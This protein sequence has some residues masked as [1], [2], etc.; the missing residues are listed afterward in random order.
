M[1]Y[2]QPRTQAAAPCIQVA[3]VRAPGGEG[4]RGARDPAARGR[5][6]A[7]TLH[8]L[9]AEAAPNMAAA[10]AAAGWRA[11]EARSAAG[12]AAGAAL[13]VGRRGG[14][15][16]G[17]VCGRGG[18]RGAGTPGARRL[19]P[20]NLS[21]LHPLAAW[22]TGWAG[23]GGGIQG[24]MARVSIGSAATIALWPRPTHRPSPPHVARQREAAPPRPPHLGCP[25]SAA[26]RVPAVCI[27]AP[28]APCIAATGELSL[29]SPT[30][31]RG[32]LATPNP[33]PSPSPHPNPGE[34]LCTFNGKYHLAWSVPM[35]DPSYFMPSAQAAY[36]LVA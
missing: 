1:L 15:L 34:K 6:G 27:A 29:S 9:L 4:L 21:A 19:G 33:N 3:P 12:A 23:R 5:A 16:G 32:C 24:P 36:S 22:R 17:G 8:A 35:A 20:W 14:G 28:R 31:A 7:R 10:A 18:A 26:P 13:G 11:P 30:R 25:T 2:L